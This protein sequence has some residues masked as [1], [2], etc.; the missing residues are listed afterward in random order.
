[1]GLRMITYFHH[2]DD[3][4]AN[5]GDGCTSTSMMYGR[6]L[7]FYNMSWETVRL[8]PTYHSLHMAIRGR[9]KLNNLD[10]LV[11]MIA[12]YIYICLVAEKD[13]ANWQLSMTSNIIIC[14][15]WS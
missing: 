7:I 5:A 3:A 9:V 12:I 2:F 6:S 10:H 4:D 15:C 13:P 8:S 1:M 14:P 11:I